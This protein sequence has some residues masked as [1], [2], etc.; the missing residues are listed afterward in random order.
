MPLFSGNPVPRPL[1]L[2]SH[3]QHLE[4]L[5]VRITFVNDED[6]KT[7]TPARTLFLQGSPWGDAM[8]ACIDTPMSVEWEATT[9]SM[10][11]Y[12]GMR[13]N[14]PQR[15]RS[16]NSKKATPRLMAHFNQPEKEAPPPPKLA[17]AGLGMNAALFEASAQKT[18]RAS[19]PVSKTIARTGS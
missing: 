4:P 10:D 17:N 19:A 16:R 9:L 18:G 6:A 15:R 1:V 8:V 5:H 14:G 3:T 2:Q 7:R 12:E 11:N 13:E